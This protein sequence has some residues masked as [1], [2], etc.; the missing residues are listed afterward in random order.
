MHSLNKLPDGQRM[1]LQL[2]ARVYGNKSV[3]ADGPSLATPPTVLG[4]TVTLTYTGAADGLHVSAVS[5]AGPGC[6]VS[7]FEFGFS[8]GSWVRAANYTIDPAKGSVVL[9]GAESE[10]SGVK[11]TEVRYAWE[12]FPQCIL[13]SGLVG[14]WNDTSRGVLPSPPFRSAVATGCESAQTACA[15]S[16]GTQCCIN[17]DV[18][19]YLQGGEICMPHGGGCQCKG[20]VGSTTPTFP[21]AVSASNVM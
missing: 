2:L 3:V 21:P 10:E 17:T 7:P 9:A 18:K 14:G 19:P 8:D 11:L 15:V 13:Y 20:C 4:S 6:A 5:G 12:G 16:D 1:G